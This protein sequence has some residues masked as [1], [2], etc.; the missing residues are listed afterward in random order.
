MGP[1]PSCLRVRFNFPTQ[2]THVLGF[3]LTR[4]P[5]TCTHNPE[6]GSR[7]AEQLCARG[8]TIYPACQNEMRALVAMTETE[9]E[10][11]VG[12][13]LRRSQAAIPPTQPGVA[14]RDQ[15]YRGGVCRSRGEVGR[16]P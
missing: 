2:P 14:A 4:Q 11:G 16:P 9:G 15:G 1:L 7:T 8:A 3:L 5:P 12:P 13:H 6:L 10:V